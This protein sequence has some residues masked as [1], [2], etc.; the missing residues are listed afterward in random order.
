[1]AGLPRKP[2]AFALPRNGSAEPLEQFLEA[3]RL[4]PLVRVFRWTKP[5]AN[6]SRGGCAAPGL[7]C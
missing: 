6:G 1:M 4:P 2:E 7:R 5:R 3:R